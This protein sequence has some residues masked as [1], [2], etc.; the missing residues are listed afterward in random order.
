[1]TSEVESHP[2]CHPHSEQI[3]KQQPGTRYGIR[4]EIALAPWS[5][6][7]T[8]PSISVKTCQSDLPILPFQYRNSPP[9]SAGSFH[10]SIPP[11][12]SHR[13]IDRSMLGQLLVDAP[14]LA[15]DLP[16]STQFCVAFLVILTTR[17]HN[18]A[19]YEFRLMVTFT[20]CT[21]W[22]HARLVMVNPHPAQVTEVWLRW[23]LT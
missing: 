16:V 13:S 8:H 10:R 15:A 2:P 9:H 18:I 20:A 7:M 17:T 22:G 1:M 5:I 4:Y 12:H 23:I 11:A 3:T 21:S 14:W 6:Y 19:G